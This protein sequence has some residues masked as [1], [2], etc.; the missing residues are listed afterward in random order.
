M[1][2]RHPANPFRAMLLG[3]ALLGTLGI[4]GCA[5][6]DGSSATDRDSHTEKKPVFHMITHGMPGDPFWSQVQRGWKDACQQFNI[7]G[8]YIGVQQD[9]NVGQMLANLETVVST[10]SDGMACVISDQETLETPLRQMIEDG[11]PVIAVN[12]KDQRGE[13]N[14]IPYLTYVGEGSYETGAASAKA[15]LERFQKITGRP[16][17]H[18]AFV[19]HAVGVQCLEDRARG[20]EDV[21]TAAGTKFDMI[22]SPSEP[23]RVQENIRAF[24]A[25]NEDVEAVHAGASQITHFAVSILKQMN[26]LGN[27][28]EP[29]EEGRVYVGG[30]DMDKQL[31]EDVRIGDAVATIDQQPYYQGYLAALLLYQYHKYRLIPSSDILTGPY[32]VD[33]ANAEQRIGQIKALTE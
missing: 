27:V 17:K 6:A 29:F 18:A 14:R 7:D 15:V 13:S 33:Q 2:L 16:P 9:G 20:M 4:F 23:S 10:G 8:R 12:I 11:I 5:G 32:V 1:N 28:N 26:R 19:N 25:A 24:V 21:Y 31:L 22:A 3:I 30:I